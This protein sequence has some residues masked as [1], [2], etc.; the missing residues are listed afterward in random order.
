[1]KYVVKINR[2]DINKKLDYSYDNPCITCKFCHFSFLYN[3]L[4]W[5]SDEDSDGNYYEYQ[6]GCPICK[7]YNC[8][9]IEIE[10]LSNEELA[11]IV[12]V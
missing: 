10:K 1:M 9:E 11:K 12:E 5:D 4:L 3:E 7:R 6:Y 8:C 2:N